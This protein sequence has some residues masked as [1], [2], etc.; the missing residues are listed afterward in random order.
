MQMRRLLLAAITGA[1]VGCGADSNPAKE[2]VGE[3]IQ[4]LVTDCEYLN[5]DLYKPL[6]IPVVFEHELL[7]TDLSVVE[8]PCRTSM[9]PP[10]PP[11]CAGSSDGEWTFNYLMKGMSGNL[12]IERFVAEWIHTFEVNQTVNSFTVPARTNARSKLIDPWLVASGCAAGAPIVGANACTLD[13]SKAPFILLAIVNRVDLAGPI[14][15]GRPGE[16]RFVFGLKDPNNANN[17]DFHTGI[18]IEYKL[19]SSLD[20]I[21]WAELWHDLAKQPMGSAAYLSALEVITDAVTSIGAEPGALNNGSA[22]GQIR[23]NDLELGGSTQPWELRQYELTDVG[24]GPDRALLT[25]K[26][27]ADSPSP[28]LNNSALL[29]QY[30]ANNQQAILDQTHVV[31]LTYQSSVFQGGAGHVTIQ[32]GFPL[33]TWQAPNASSEVRHR[34]AF[35][36]CGGCHGGETDTDITEFAHVKHRI[37]GLQSSTSFFLQTSTQPKASNSGL[38]MFTF[39]VPDPIQPA[40]VREYNEPWRRVCEMTR[41]LNGDPIP[42]TNAI[43]AH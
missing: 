30:I 27:V 22:L 38:P 16:L 23:T 39:A 24:M 10:P 41:L 12:T 35:A 15:G 17:V 25:L 8:D 3:A 18:I 1:A 36:T 19:P 6:E 42:Y 31:P 9:N 29:D 5:E 26:P 4:A 28:S 14:P 33:F 21:Q 40:I 11:A 32:A 43:G 34:F 37:T 13:M 2:R 7:I 20:A